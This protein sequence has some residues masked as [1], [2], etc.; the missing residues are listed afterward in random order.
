MLAG[1]TRQSNAEAIV[2]EGKLSMEYF[3][4]H[5]KVLQLLAKWKPPLPAYAH[6][7]PHTWLT[8]CALRY[9]KILTC[10]GTN[11]KGLGPKVLVE[12]RVVSRFGGW[13]TDVGP[14]SES[15][16]AP[17]EGREWGGVSSEEWE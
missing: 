5:G 15:R 7:C 12:V 4:K 1:K 11:R 14:M 17:S 3:R 10:S 6:T 9:L 2:G 16:D 13:N 8:S